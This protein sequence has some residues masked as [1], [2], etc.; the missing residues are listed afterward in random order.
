MLGAMSPGGRSAPCTSCGGLTALLFALLAWPCGPARA[1]IRLDAASIAG[2]GGLSD[3]LGPWKY[4]AGD[5]PA[6]ADPD[7]DRSGW[8]DV[9][10][11]FEPV[12]DD[13]EGIAWLAAEL[14]VA[15]DLVDRPLLLWLMHLGALELYLDGERIYRMGDL[16]QARD[17]R[18][19]AVAILP[20][21]NASV[22]FAR[23][24]RHV[25]ALRFASA[26][27]RW[28]EAVGF[29][30]LLQ[31]YLG[32]AERSEPFARHV[33]NQVLFGPTLV[34]GAALVLMLLHSLLFLFYPA[35]REN[36]YYSLAAA[37]MG[38]I[39]VG[40]SQ[41]SNATDLSKFVFYHVLF[42]LSVLAIGLFH[43]RFYYAIFL[44]RVPRYY[45]G[46][47]AV[48]LGLMVFVKPLPI[49]AI[50]IFASAT[51]PEAVRVL[52]K[53]LRAGQR[54][55]WLVAVGGAAFAVGALLQMV[56]EMVGQRPPFGQAYLFGFLA[57]M[58]AMSTYLARDIA[59]ANTE[60]S[61]LRDLEVAHRDLQATQAKLVQSEKMASLGQLVAGVA[62][63]INTPVGAV[64][65]VRDS[66]TRS[67]V[68]LHRALSQELPGYQEVRD[69]ARPL[70]V[71][72]DAAQVIESGSTRVSE[73]VKRLKRFARLDEAERQSA[74]LHDGIDDTLLLLRHEMKHGIEVVKHYGDIPEVSCFP[75]ELN[76]VFLN[77]LLNAVQALEG[78]GRIDITTR[79]DGEHVCIDITDDGPGI[80]K[81]NLSR[82]FDPGFTTKGVR[83]GTGLGLSICYRIVQAHE[84]EIVVV[85]TLGHG[86]T[87]SVR[88]PLRPSQVG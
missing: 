70:K 73:I 13:Y 10:A 41:M 33:R 31:V 11:G 59:A 88:L 12:P 66:I 26:R 44:R 2:E 58:V 75:S 32:D 69:I 45:W 55:A 78:K 52:I 81:E 23:L 17:G 16:A 20:E 4:R 43:L 72:D 74:N 86:A 40:S 64:A 27:A 5:D 47:V 29:G 46:I 48:G 51:F 62:H 38:G 36:L 82:I 49:A 1:Q 19:I 54:D 61:L 71:L 8:G 34:T 85:S 37:A 22:R 14:D 18:R 65:S 83:V 56:P 15:P 30:A 35:K 67:L 53:A 28:V 24:G 50:Y 21:R 87:F 6:W 3:R 80:A 57:L 9:G 77:L 68:K 79:V 7:Y 25:L 76:Q 39:A 42:K 84:G 60:L 63:E